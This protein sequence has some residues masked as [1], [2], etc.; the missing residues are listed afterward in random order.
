MNKI[1]KMESHAVDNRLNECHG[2]SVMTGKIAA[3]RFL[4]AFR[5]R[6]KEED[7]DRIRKSYQC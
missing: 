7:F 4:D 3:E 1:E 5:G 6:W 2:R